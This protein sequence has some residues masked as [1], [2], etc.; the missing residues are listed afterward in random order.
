MSELMDGFHPGILPHLTSLA[1]IP[2]WGPLLSA[3][4]LASP[5]SGLLGDSAVIDF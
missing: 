2:I 5:F 4:A 1:K 3:L